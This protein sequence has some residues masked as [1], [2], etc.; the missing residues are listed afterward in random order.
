MTQPSKKRRGLIGELPHAPDQ[1]QI[2]SLQRETRYQRDI[3]SLSRNK[4]GSL[5]P[6]ERI[7]ANNRET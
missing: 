6:E 7:V 4:D 3:P 5:C 1:R 2:V